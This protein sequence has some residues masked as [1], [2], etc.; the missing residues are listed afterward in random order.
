MGL[1]RGLSGKHLKLGGT[2]LIPF[3]RTGAILLCCLLCVLPV[4]GQPQA[5]GQQAGQIDAMIPA[6]SAGTGTA[7]T[8][9]GVDMDG[10]KF[11]SPP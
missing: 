3:K 1:L 9:S 5:A 7:L 8:G 10:L 11:A 6:A 4:L 2:T